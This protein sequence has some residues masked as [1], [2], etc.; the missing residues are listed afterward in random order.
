MPKQEEK[1]GATVNHLLIL[2]E[3]ENIAKKQQQK[4]NLHGL[5]RL[6]QGSWQSMVRSN[7][8]R[9]AQRS[10]KEQT[11]ENDKETQWKSNSEDSNKIRRNQE[12]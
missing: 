10:N 12:E 3:V 5:P 7:N 4:N 1:R 9:D 2:L 8:V 6:D 11:W